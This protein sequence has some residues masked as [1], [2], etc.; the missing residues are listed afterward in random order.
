MHRL[1]NDFQIFHFSSHYTI[2]QKTCH[3]TLTIL[4]YDAMIEIFETKFF[5]LSQKFYDSFGNLKFSSHDHDALIFNREMAAKRWSCVA[6]IILIS[7]FLLK[8][9]RHYRGSEVKE[10]II[11]L[12]LL[13]GCCRDQMLMRGGTPDEIKILYLWFL[14]IFLWWNLKVV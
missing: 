11:L 4:M 2:L 6:F 10:E 14:F 5:F 13:V 7:I 12:E 1:W 9:V 3:W 8:I